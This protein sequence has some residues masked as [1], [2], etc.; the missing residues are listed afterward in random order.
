MRKA[1]GEQDKLMELEADQA[2]LEFSFHLVKWQEAEMAH[3][4]NIPSC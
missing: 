2:S 1:K 3:W 4:N